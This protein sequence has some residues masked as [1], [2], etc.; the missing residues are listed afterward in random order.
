MIQQRL[1][2]A[3]LIPLVQVACWF[4]TNVNTFH[5]STNSISHNCNTI[6]QITNN[7]NVA[8]LP[9][10]KAKNESKTVRHIK[11]SYKRYW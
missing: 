5:P 3:V 11:F 1:N 7:A 2:H 6:I 8:F 9:V 10:E 4:M